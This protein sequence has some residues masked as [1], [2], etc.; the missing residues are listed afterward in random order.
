MGVGVI[1]LIV[2]CICNLMTRSKRH[3]LKFVNVL[4]FFWLVWVAFQ[5]SFSGVGAERIFLAGLPVLAMVSS[6]LCYLGLHR[7]THLLTLVCA[8]VH[9]VVPVGCL[10]AAMNVVNHN[11]YTCTLCMGASV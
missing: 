9:G 5:A 2:Q 6:L 3:L 4:V 7:I 11:C 8:L 1:T 10:L